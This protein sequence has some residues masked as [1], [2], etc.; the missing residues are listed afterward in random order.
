MAKD[1]AGM[2]S[3]KPGLNSRRRIVSQKMYPFSMGKPEDIAAVALFLACDDSRML[4]GTTIAADGGRSS[5][6]R[7]YAPEGVTMALLD[8]DSSDC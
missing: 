4:T 5:Y 6:I 2:L 7:M 3:A 1:R 8:G